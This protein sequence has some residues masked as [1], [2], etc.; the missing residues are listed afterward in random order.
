MSFLLKFGW[1]VVALGVAG[2][3]F[4]F[5]VAAYRFL[6]VGRFSQSDV[7]TGSALMFATM[8]FWL[9]NV[10]LARRFARPAAGLPRP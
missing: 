5:G 7:V 1:V 3:L 6:E 8:A 9:G 2:T 10:R 4:I